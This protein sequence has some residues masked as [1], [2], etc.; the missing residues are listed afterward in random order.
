MAVGT[1]LSPMVGR[2]QALS[3]LLEWLGRGE[4]LIT[5]T[6]SAGIGKTRLVR[7]LLSRAKH[8][9]PESVLFCDL[10]EARDEADLWLA[11]SRTFQAENEVGKILARVQQ[12]GVVLLALDNFEQLSASCSGAVAQLCGA[13]PKLQVVVTTRSLLRVAPEIVFE[14]SPLSVP[15]A[16]Q[17][18][19]ES[20]DLWTS[21]RGR[22]ETAYRASREDPQVLCELLRALEG[23]PLAIEL[24]AARASL[25]GTRELLSRLTER[26]ALL[27]H[28]MRGAPE[29]QATL[30]GAIAWS[31]QLLG[32]DELEVM[33]QCSVFRGGFSVEDAEHVV[34]RTRLEPPSSVLDLLQSL[35]EQSL[36]RIEADE[37][38]V[39]F[40]MFASIREY[41]EARLE[42]RGHARESFERHAAWFGPRAEALAEAV[43]GP[44][45]TCALDALD[46]DRDN[47]VAVASRAL[48]LDQ[49]TSA[50]L[51]DAARCL[52]G[53]DAVLWTRG[54]IG[55]HLELWER[56]L[57]EEGRAPRLSPKYLCRT[58]EARGLLLSGRGRGAEGLVDV[59]RALAIAEQSGDPLLLS[60]TLLGLSWIHMRV[61]HLSRMEEAITRGREL[62]VRAQDRR[63]E[64]IFVDTL[65]VVAKERGDLTRAESLSREALAMHREVRNRRWEGVALGR[66]AM[67]AMERGDFDAARLH[68]EQAI[69][70][71]SALKSRYVE[72]VLWMTLAVAHY[73]HGD[74]ERARELMRNALGMYLRVGEHRAHGVARA[75]LGAM[76]FELGEGE[77]ALSDLEQGY[78]T[79]LSAQAHRIAVVFGFFLAAFEAHLGRFARCEAHL[80]QARAIL[81]EHPDARVDLVRALVEAQVDVCRLSE[82]EEERARARLAADAALTLAL[83]PPDSQHVSVS[84]SVDV[85]LAVRMLERAIGARVTPVNPSSELVVHALGHWFERDGA[86]RVPLQN[87]P[88]LRRILVRL[89]SQ[90]V[91]RPRVPLTAEQL[92]AT[93]WPD[94]KMSRDSASNRLYVTLNR[95]RGLGLRELLVAEGGGYYLDPSALVRMSP[96]DG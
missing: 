43:D 2:N 80:D 90:R 84:S 7:E 1:A 76:S 10:T 66:L 56:L 5:I 22:S 12:H 86:E 47:L 60:R 39:R 73:S 31:F 68:A 20:Y 77:A 28:G 87:R 78:E 91:Q 67:L 18:N 81:R 48:S 38:C 41:A 72:A 74:T 63:L 24:T 9:S 37:E 35:R 55:A 88:A 27:R 59:E 51:Q 83:V 25:L 19:S 44:D 92:V 30:E 46:R 64:G 29:R 70:I 49:A 61:G 58:L 50:H 6:G 62:A 95:L 96:A 33:T 26:F 4:R 85:R 71:H 54:P 3:T 52:I 34:D 75:Y 23:V 11:L 94:E 45:G 8:V 21:R 82:S 93:G 40:F 15:I 14:L 89:A 32:A 16:D 42:E 69:A 53:L 17:P 13:C 79:L 36:L 57:A 65:S